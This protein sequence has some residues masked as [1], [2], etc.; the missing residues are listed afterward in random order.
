MHQLL[1]VAW[2]QAT[3]RRVLQRQPTFPLG[4][5]SG[6]I[7]GCNGKRKTAS[8]CKLMALSALRGRISTD[9]D[10]LLF[11]VPALGELMLEES[12]LPYL[13]T[14]RVEAFTPA[15]SASMHE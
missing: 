5:T 10:G 11:P 14:M 4:V 9:L 15:V 1:A 2:A 13:S 7:Y 6:V 12:V 8:L 3:L